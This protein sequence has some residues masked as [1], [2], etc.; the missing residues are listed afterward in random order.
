MLEFRHLR[1]F[2][3]VAEE[4]SFT[5]AAKC[6]NL[7]HPS[8]HQ[9]IGRLEEI[10]G[11]RLFNRDGHRI[12]LTKAGSAFLEN[13]REL[14]KGAESA[15]QVARHAGQDLKKFISVGIA[16][17][18]EP[19]V[20]ATVMPLFLRRHPE[21]H[22]EVCSVPYKEQLSALLEG[23]INVVI[24][25]GSMEH[26]AVV[27]EVID[28][29]RIVAILPADHPLAKQERIAV[30]SF[31]ALP[32]IMPSRTAMPHIYGLWQTLAAQ[33]GVRFHG[34][35]TMTDNVFTVVPAVGAGCGA[36]L[37]PEYVLPF[38]HSNVVGRELDLDPQPLLDR[39]VAYCKNDDSTALNFFLQTVRAARPN[40]PDSSES[41]SPASA[42]SA[43]RESLSVKKYP[44][45]PRKVD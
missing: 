28:R 18:C 5:R 27:S 22:I 44:I 24:L 3:A 37:V 14:L 34:N 30:Q 33:A 29:S 40:A 20:M 31:A 32:L 16:P 13:A 38:P 45:G 36:S 35:I 9:Q 17:G 43:R 4:E 26:S 15:I 23:T 25:E 8:L 11:T 19:I 2:V 1:Y 12:Q 21:I 42:N 6:L 39:I 10:V 41:V 7:S